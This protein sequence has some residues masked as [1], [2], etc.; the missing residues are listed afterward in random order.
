MPM[1]RNSL[2]FPYK[3]N[4]TKIYILASIFFEKDDKYVFKARNSCCVY[5]EFLVFKYV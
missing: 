3:L 1:L 2:K 4:Q 5:R